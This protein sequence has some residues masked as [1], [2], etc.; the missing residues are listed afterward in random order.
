MWSNTGMDHLLTSI[1][2]G[3]HN[4][5]E[6]LNVCCV[7][8]GCEREQDSPWQ[9]SCVNCHLILCRQLHTFLLQLRAWMGERARH[10]CRACRTCVQC[11]SHTPH[12][13]QVSLQRCYPDISLSHGLRFKI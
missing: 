11:L 1:E 2:N 7:R 5:G 12:P 8:S 9:R 13:S 3:C 4:T 10:Y 6:C